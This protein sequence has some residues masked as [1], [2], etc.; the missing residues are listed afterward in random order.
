MAFIRSTL[1]AEAKRTAIPV[2]CGSS[3]VIHLSLLKM[4][5]QNATAVS[6]QAVC[7]SK[8]PLATNANGFVIRIRK[9][10]FSV[11]QDDNLLSLT[12]AAT[13]KCSVDPDDW[14][15]NPEKMR[16][17]KYLLERLKEQLVQRRDQHVARIKEL[18]V[19]ISSQIDILK[20]RQKGVNQSGGFTA[21][22]RVQL[23]AS[24]TVQKIVLDASRIQAAPQEKYSTIHTATAKLVQIATKIRED[25]KGDGHRKRS[26]DTDITGDLVTVKNLIVSNSNTWKG[27]YD[28]M[29]NHK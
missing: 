10:E 28:S 8:E 20:H 14:R 29:N 23:S 1:T 17:I 24:S 18:L 15:A 13:T 25:R 22:Q 3:D 12:A 9:S 5:G 6:Y 7:V 27:I 19:G 21:A 2:R 4:R 26:V 11:V 16:R